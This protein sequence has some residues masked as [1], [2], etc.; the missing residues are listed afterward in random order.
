M[1]YEKLSRRAIICIFISELIEIIVKYI[2]LMLILYIPFKIVPEIISIILLILIIK[3]ILYLII[4]PIL[5]Y[6]R[7]RLLITENSIEIKNGFLFVEINI[8]PIERIHKITIKKSPIDKLFRLSKVILTTAGG[9]IT[10]KFLGDEKV[11]EISVILK[12]KIN[13]ISR[14]EKLNEEHLF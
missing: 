9:D 3:D 6:E 1:Q 5:K 8:V 10:I 2:I 4:W 14:E 11:E 12:D 7:Y 13:E